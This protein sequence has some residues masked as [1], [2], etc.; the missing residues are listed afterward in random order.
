MA[1]NLLLASLRNEFRRPLFDQLVPVPLEKGR[2][3]VGVDQPSDHV[4]FPT[5]GLVSIVGLTGDGGVVELA[6]VSRSGCIGLT[7]EL[8]VASTPHQ[9]TVCL[10]GAALRLKKQTLVAAMGQDD[11][12]RNALLNHANRWSSELAQAVVC[13]RFH[14][15]RQRLCRWLLTAAD[16]TDLCVLEITHEMLA[17]VL[18]VARPVLSR[19]ALELHDADAIRSRRGRV[20]LINRLS[21]EQLACECYDLIRGATI[22]GGMGNQVD[23]GRTTR[24]YW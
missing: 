15:V 24:G 5:R 17:P 7:E 22:A 16:R 12:L 9:A 23:T 13:H 18:G 6:A 21:L 14:S 8:S 10:P 2:N 1:E 19:A 11:V 20:T 4:Y 3:L